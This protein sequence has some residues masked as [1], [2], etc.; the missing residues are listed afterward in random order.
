[1]LRSKVEKESGSVDGGRVRWGMN[2]WPRP[3]RSLVP[4][5]G[6]Y[7]LQRLWKKRLEG[8]EKYTLVGL[9]CK[10]SA[11]LDQWVKVSLAVNP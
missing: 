6:W 8:V 5:G 1:M 7:F 4:G 2:L 3:R 9:F 11:L 10:T